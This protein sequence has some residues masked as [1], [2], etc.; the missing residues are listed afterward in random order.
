MSKL[1][2]VINNM[3][4]SSPKDV[5]GTN[6]LS[7]YNYEEYLWSMIYSIFKFE[8]L[9]PSYDETYLKEVLFKNGYIGTFIKDGVPYCL[10][11]GYNGINVY[12]RP[13]EL[14]V[15]NP[16]LGNFNATL[17]KDCTLVYYNYYNGAPQNLRNLVSQY[18]TMLAS[19]DCSI[20]VSLMNSRVAHIFKAKNKKELMTYKQI[21]S[22]VSNGKPAITLYSPTADSFNDTS[23]EF[24]D[25]K[26]QYIANDVL[27]TKR[28]IM[29]EFL[30]RIGIM[31]VNTQ[32]KE[33]QVVDEVNANNGETLALCSLWLHNLQEC[34]K[35][36]NRINKLNGVISNIT[37]EYNT[38]V[39]GSLQ[40]EYTNERNKLD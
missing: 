13:Y 15:S 34:F 35:E 12:N 36:V 33:R 21:Y 6:S 11:C 26:N 25:V 39:I 40:K 17:K 29:N 4:R 38:E 31:N 14:I 16:V 5:E 37:V 10:E 3:F 9:L 18:A 30:T 32:K 27:L 23:N 24:L 8:N 19:C 2:D 22:D 28:T 7:Y 1:M 20:N